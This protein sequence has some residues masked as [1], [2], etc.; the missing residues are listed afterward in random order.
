MGVPKKEAKTGGYGLYDLGAVDQGRD[1]LDLCDFCRSRT[2]GSD[3]FG[4][5]YA[6]EGA[7]CFWRDVR[8]VGS[9]IDC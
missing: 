3:A 7:Y 5:H 4:H 9:D 8:A 2:V 6:F 1:V